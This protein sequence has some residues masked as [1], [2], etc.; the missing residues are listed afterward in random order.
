MFYLAIV[1]RN[2]QPIN[3]MHGLFS[4]MLKIWNQ[5]SDLL[6][7]VSCLQVCAPYQIDLQAAGGCQRDAFLLF[8]LNERF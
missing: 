5:G 7:V 3:I 8:V 2:Q 4:F 6:I 1:V